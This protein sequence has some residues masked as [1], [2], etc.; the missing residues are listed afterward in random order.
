MLPQSMRDVASYS[1]RGAAT[2]PSCRPAGAALGLITPDLRC[3]ST[4]FLFLMQLE[5]VVGKGYP[6]VYARGFLNPCGVSNEVR[7]LSALMSVDTISIHERLNLQTV[8]LTRYCFSH[9]PYDVFHS[10]HSPRRRSASATLSSIA[11]RMPHV[12]TPES[13]V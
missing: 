3:D 6:R 11:Q 7:C 12:Q 4:P 10:T 5:L 13:P 8:Q 9:R 1:I 2:T